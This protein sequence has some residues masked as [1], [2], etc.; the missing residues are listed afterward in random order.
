MVEPRSAGF[1]Y[2]AEEIANMSRLGVVWPY[3]LRVRKTPGI[4]CALGA[5]FRKTRAHLAARTRKPVQEANWNLRAGRRLESLQ[6]SAKFVPA[7]VRNN[8]TQGTQIFEE[9][10]K[11]CRARD[12]EAQG[13]HVEKRP[14]RTQG[15]EP[16]AGD[17]DRPF[18]GARCRAKGAKEGNRRAPRQENQECEEGQA[19]GRRINLASFGVPFA[20]PS[21]AGGHYN[22]PL[23]MRSSVPV[24]RYSLA[25]EKPFHLPKKAG[26]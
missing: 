3:E 20:F 19:Q 9:G 22:A 5:S 2:F 25:A 26:F 24:L 14:F 23:I 13:R 6:Q 21:G 18:R 8:G 15:Q 17:R 4:L 10:V 7:G 16:Q 11:L 1:G 12:E